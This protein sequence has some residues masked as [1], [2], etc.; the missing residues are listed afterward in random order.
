MEEDVE[1]PLI[2][3]W[4]FLAIARAI[5]NV[6]NGK[7]TFKVEQEEVVFNL[8]NVNKYPYTD[9]CYRV[10][11]INELAKEDFDKEYLATTSFEVGQQVLLSNSHS[12]LFPW[13]HKSRWSGPFK[14]VKFYPYGIIEIDS[15]DADTFMVN[16]L[17]L[18]PYFVDEIIF[19]TLPDPPNNFGDNDEDDKQK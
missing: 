15:K 8:F 4:P 14:V 19:I 17:C 12:K 3:G 10:G 7:I 5:I 16:G 1:I 2:L 9:S 6:K 13:K 18:K 11:S